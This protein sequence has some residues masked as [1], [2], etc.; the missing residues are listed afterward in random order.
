LAGGAVNGTLYI[1]WDRYVHS[2]Y[3]LTKSLL[4][5][6]MNVSNQISEEN[7]KKFSPYFQVTTFIYHNFLKA[8]TSNH[9]FLTPHITGPNQ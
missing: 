7:I 9:P 1:K 6:P 2:R 3:P 4:S 8:R 5:V